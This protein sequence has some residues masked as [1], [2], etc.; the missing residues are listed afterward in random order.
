MKVEIGESLV[1][2]WL[3]H[4]QGCPIVQTNWKPS[5]TWPIRRETRLATS[6]EK[7]RGD[8]RQRLG[9]ELFKKSPFHQF[10]RQTEIDV[11][12]LRFADARSVAIAV[13]SAF[14]ENGVNYGALEETVGRILK[15][16][17]RATFALEAYFELHQADIIFVTPKMH[18]AVRNAIQSCWPDL[19]S[20]LSDC[21][22]LSVSRLELRI[23][24]NADF[25]EQ[26]LRPVL[27]RVDQVSDTSE[28]FMRSQQL[29][30]FC[31]ISS[32][33][34]QTRSASPRPG[35]DSEPKI[36]EH[37]RQTMVRLAEAGRLTPP[38]LEQLADSLYCKQ[39][40]NLGHPF[41]RIMDPSKAPHEQR[42]D[43]RRYAR[44]W[45]E[46]FRVGSRKFYAC[47]QWF[48]HQRPAFDRWARDLELARQP[49]SVACSDACSVGPAGSTGLPIRPRF[50]F[51]R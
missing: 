40:F 28:L 46:P 4:V 27:G 19:Q 1:F 38:V 50:R 48:E 43:E 35:N 32:W 51:T 39:T 16:L 5:P 10:L 36:G 11:L 22:G 23:V 7:M 47:S 9:F 12:G 44:Y 6:F 8:A 49:Q 3:R 17:I 24:A 2:S 25:V 45:S 15:K 31:E 42:L 30:S 37:V 26:V 20:T 21:G 13:D 41:L 18:N 34:P 14:H 29:V 33:S